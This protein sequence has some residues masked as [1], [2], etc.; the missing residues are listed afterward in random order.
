VISFAVYKRGF[1]EPEAESDKAELA[2]KEQARDA[3]GVQ[4]ARVTLVAS[5]NDPPCV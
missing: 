3:G 2:L 4:A 5:P 1:L